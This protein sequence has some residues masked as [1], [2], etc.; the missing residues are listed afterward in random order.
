[1][2]RRNLVA[3]FG[4]KF[5]IAL[6]SFAFIPAHVRMLGLEG[7]G[8]LGVLLS[9]Q[10]L[11][12]VFDFGLSHT[13]TRESARLTALKQRGAVRTLL[14]TFEICYWVVAVCLGI[15]IYALAPFIQAW[16]NYSTLSPTLA[17]QSLALFAIVFALNWPSALYSGALAGL[18][19]HVPLNI[20]GAAAA[21]ARNAGGVVVLW[22]SS[23]DLPTLLVWH[24]LVNAVTTAALR[25]T[26]GTDASIR[27]P[28]RR[29]DPS[30]LL[31]SWKF[32]LGVSGT[33][34]LLTILGQLDRIVLS[35]MFTLDVLAMYL[36]PLT[37]TG[38]LGYLA[39][40]ITAAFYPRFV[41]TYARRESA[42]LQRTFHL[43]CQFIGVLVV[44]A[45]AILAIFPELVLLTWTSDA[46]LSRKSAPLLQL[47]AV[48]M[49]ISLLTGVCFQVLAAAGLTRLN[50]ALQAIAVILMGVLLIY[51][52]PAHGPVGAAI[53]W[54]VV[55]G[56]L[57]AAA[58]LLTLNQLL[59]GTYR[60]WITGDVLLPSA[61]SVALIWVSS[62]MIPDTAGRFMASAWMA[63]TFLLA[64]SCQLLACS[65]LRSRL[66]AH[67]RKP[68][69]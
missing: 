40:P 23:A 34:A 5:W 50:V 11:F 45:G 18:E 41:Q 24:L 36:L 59:P 55:Y 33:L 58:P 30:M 4:G 56:V 6:M 69:K 67:L 1:M 32:S 10:G 22:I 17:Y 37:L 31:T 42:L 64:A 65:E 48:A 8:L 38:A 13:I 63:G 49:T 44:P 26:L 52:V 9:L 68:G 27:S 16:L 53:A 62:L 51:L 14:L 57:A 2:V 66:L 29:F 20:I 47:L 28:G 12:A 3:N 25:L 61:L 19:R 39:A 15:A 35:R 60:P 46:E 43:C 54:L 21:T 7:Y